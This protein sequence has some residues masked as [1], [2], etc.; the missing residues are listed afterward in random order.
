MRIVHVNIIIIIIK[1][2][3]LFFFFFCTQTYVFLIYI[4]EIISEART[5][6]VYNAPYAGVLSFKPNEHVKIF[7][8]SAGSN[9]NLWGVEINNKRGYVPKEYVRETK[10]ITKNLSHLVNTEVVKT[11]N[12][13]V[14]SI[15]VEELKPDP[16]KKSYDV[17]DGT[18]IYYNNEDVSKVEIDK[19]HVTET[20][21]LPTKVAAD[22]ENKIVEDV[23][24]E[25]I[26][27]EEDNLKDKLIDDED[28]DD[29]DLEDDEDDLEDLDDEDEDESI[30]EVDSGDMDNGKFIDLLLNE[31]KQDCGGDN[32]K[33][34]GENESN[35][36]I[37]VSEKVENDLLN[38]LTNIPVEN[39]VASPDMIDA[40]SQN[41][42]L[43]ED[44]KLDEGF[45][46]QIE[47]ENPAKDIEAVKDDT[48]STNVVELKETASLDEEIP[49]SENVSSI[50]NEDQVPPPRNVAELD[51]IS[52]IKVAVN[53]DNSFE[54]KEMLNTEEV[55]HIPY[56]DQ[57]TSTKTAEEVDT[58]K[59]TV[60][61]ASITSDNELSLP[62]ALWNIIN[63]KDLDE[64][65]ELLDAK[66]SLPTTE[67]NEASNI[68]FET[69]AS[70][71][72]SGLVNMFSSDTSASSEEN[73]ENVL[74]T[75][76][77]EMKEEEEQK[78]K[79]E[80][81]KDEVLLTTGTEAKESSSLFN[82]MP[83]LAV[84]PNP[85][86]DE[87]IDLPLT[88]TIQE[89][90]T[91]YSAIEET[92]VP[93][94]INDQSS[95]DNTKVTN[96]IPLNNLESGTEE[97]GY[98]ND[99]NGTNQVQQETETENENLKNV[100]D[101]NLNEPI[102]YLE[103]ISIPENDVN[104]DVDANKV[105][106]QNE[107]DGARKPEETVDSEDNVSPKLNDGNT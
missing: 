67:E 12:D 75:E 82:I 72:F 86:M 89:I 74:K 2:F 39:V 20:V 88:N 65:N 96:E 45:N 4:L 70:S 26:K 78:K 81:M 8:K 6:L 79:E 37:P 1:I 11:K 97:T 46:P 54:T 38:V 33:E 5:L 99:V 63:N 49:L 56:A 24:S 85:V 57:T 58:M 40:R 83:N 84:T 77:V 34:L 100:M 43:H 25:E 22:D 29:D 7:S 66:S 51:P 9:L 87:I 107:Q 55:V 14:P 93:N 104:F 15:T 17:V 71:I 73:V 80:L 30:I 21:A 36:E 47:L 35:V 53:E 90:N 19:E 50:A 105:I 68:K 27:N 41:D 42:T 69:E 95:D 3:N 13:E 28:D 60:N 48:T 44:K 103:P 18:T 23:K 64:N 94:L 101:D 91:Q 52:Q 10:V 76:G 32:C 92:T 16:V 102:S 62:G 106:D 31:T 61:E 98:I 59:T